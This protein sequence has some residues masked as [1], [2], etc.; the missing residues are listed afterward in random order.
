MSST[1]SEGDSLS[2]SLFAPADTNDAVT[3]K[4]L[5]RRRVNSLLV[6]DNEVFAVFFGAD[7]SLEVNDLLNLIVGE[8][9]LTSDELLA[10]LSV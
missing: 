3:G 7:G 8:L 10:V 4:E 2:V 5:K 1:A 6:D 9:S